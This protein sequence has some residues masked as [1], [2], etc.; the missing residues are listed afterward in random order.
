MI[1]WNFTSRAKSTAGLLIVLLAE[2]LLRHSLTQIVLFA[3]ADV[4]LNDRTL[5]KLFLA[6]RTTEIA[7]VYSVAAV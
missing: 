4:S 7:E 6:E 1:G 5:K 3:I 2:V